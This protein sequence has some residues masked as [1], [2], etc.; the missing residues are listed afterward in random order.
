MNFKDTVLQEAKIDFQYL[1]DRGFPRTGALNFVANHY[2]LDEVQRN[3]LNRSVFSKKKI[4][5][6]KKKLILLSDVKEKNVIIDGYNVL[7]TVESICNSGEEFL[8]NCDDGVTRDVKAVFGKYKK[9][10]TTL[11]ALNSIISLLKIFKPK[12]VLFFYDSP[13]S[14]SGE[15]A[16]TTLELL[17]SL[18]VPGDAQTASDVDA[19]LVRLSK[20]LDGVVATSDGIVMDK[21]ETVLDIPSYIARMKKN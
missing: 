7:I 11:E 15:L 8:V 4:K 3:Y 21:V 20:E 10:E 2:V 14:M 5:T 13:V 18:K 12:R 16:K 6:R 9:D 1:L 17:K 19:E